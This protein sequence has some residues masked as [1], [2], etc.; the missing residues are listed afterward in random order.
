MYAI[1]WPTKVQ[2]AVTGDQH[3]RDGA[4]DDIGILYYAVDLAVPL[5]SLESPV[6]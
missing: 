5:A 6:S 1:L 4:A 3:W 2:Y